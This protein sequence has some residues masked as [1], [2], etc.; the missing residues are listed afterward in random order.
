MLTD[1]L[2]QI[3][4]ALEFNQEKQVT[5]QIMSRG[6][7][8]PQEKEFLI[9][10]YV[11][12]VMQGDIWK[13]DQQE[14]EQQCQKYGQQTRHAIFQGQVWHGKIYISATDI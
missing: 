14:T 3:Q 2:N 4:M 5:W 9:Q 10:I 8:L 1:T 13:R 6:V 12:G 7:I 11:A